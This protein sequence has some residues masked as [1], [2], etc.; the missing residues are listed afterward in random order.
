[1]KEK[2]VKSA[3]CDQL[4][5]GRLCTL[6][7]K[8]TAVLVIEYFQAPSLEEWEK[9]NVETSSNVLLII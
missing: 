5:S 9:Y 4:Q 6:L 8:I 1:M 3:H 2:L 7:H